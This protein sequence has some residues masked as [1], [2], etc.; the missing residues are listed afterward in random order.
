MSPIRPDLAKEIVL[1]VSNALKI[2]PAKFSDAVFTAIKSYM[3]TKA[4]VCRVCGR[5]ITFQNE[6]EGYL[7]YYKERPESC[8]RPHWINGKLCWEYRSPEEAAKKSA[9]SSSRTRKKTCER[10]KRL[11]WNLECG[12]A[13]S[14]SFFN[15]IAMAGAVASHTSNTVLNKTSN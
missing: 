10:C 6:Y 5:H 9:A 15:A 3:H 11:A 12:A 4:G 2:S 8:S 7:S 1:C 14:V 13:D